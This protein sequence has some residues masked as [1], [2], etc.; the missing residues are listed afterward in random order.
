MITSVTLLDV[1]TQSDRTALLEGA[2]NH[3]LLPGSWECFS[4]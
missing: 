1:A 3:T 2:H 4:V